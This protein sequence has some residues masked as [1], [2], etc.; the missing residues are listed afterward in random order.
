TVLA[1]G[2]DIR[3]GI[4]RDWPT[5]YRDRFG[6]DVEVVYQPRSLA[7]N[8]RPE[9]YRVERR[10]NG[11]RAWFG[12][13]ERLLEPGVHTY[14]WRYE[15]DRVLGFFA[16]GDELYWNVTGLGWAFPIE[17]ASATVRFAFDL[18]EGA[19]E[20]DAATGPAG[21]RGRAFTASIQG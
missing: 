12:S 16:E 11:V 6:N 10:G 17:R 5:R 2:V 13:P 18:P 3:R 8:G 19:V 20:V 14:A 4:Y 21:A 9:P 7:R 15:A 1:E